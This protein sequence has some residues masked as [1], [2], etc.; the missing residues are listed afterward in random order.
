M[1]CALVPYAK[2]EKMKCS[3]KNRPAGSALKVLAVLLDVFVIL[4][5][6]QLLVSSMARIDPASVTETELVQLQEEN[7]QLQEKV[8]KLQKMNALQFENISTLKKKV[9]ERMPYLADSGGEVSTVVITREGQ[10]VF[11]VTADSER[12]RMD[13][14][15]RFENWLKR[16]RL[17]PVIQVA[18]QR[19]A[20]YEKVTRVAALIQQYQPGTK[21][22]FGAG[23]KTR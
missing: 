14:L 5:V 21:L 20:D 2:P 15:V 4:V 19:G 1:S 23:V 3:G 6:F 17:S 9:D 12:M 10:V 8:D 11:E 18:G 13:S 16:H 22:Y 7:R